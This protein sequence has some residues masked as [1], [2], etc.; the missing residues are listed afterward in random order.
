MMRLRI[1]DCGLRTSR[2]ASM[3]SIALVAIVVL[4]AAPVE[5]FAQRPGTLPTQQSGGR[6]TV[7]RTAKWAL[8]GGAIGLGAYALHHSFIAER[9]YGEL[10]DVCFAA[11]ERCEMTGGKYRDP[12]T[13]ALYTRSVSAD[14]HA[15]VG[16]F[17]GQV[18]LLGSVGL[19]IYDLRNGRGPRDIPYPSKRSVGV[20]MSVP[21]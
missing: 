8:L 3:W 6:W 20:G 18:A 9:A 7:V 2:A 21:F 11:P 13:E 16:I 4:L 5:A 10:H 1:A 17:G 12:A 15:Q 19:F 14:R